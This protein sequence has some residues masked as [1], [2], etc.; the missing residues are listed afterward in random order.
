M[1]LFSKRSKAAT[2]IAVTITGSGGILSNYAYATI[3][4]TKY[5]SATD[6]LEVMPGDTIS[7][8]VY[9]ESSSG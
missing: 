6:G 4:G 5:T 2:P 7:F 1:I 8:S 3:N 9:G